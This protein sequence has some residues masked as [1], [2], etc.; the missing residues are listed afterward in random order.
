MSGAGK[1][2]NVEWPDRFTLYRVFNTDTE[3][4]YVGET[5]AWLEHR[6]L[7]RRD[8]HVD[9]AS[10][11]PQDE[12]KDL[13]RLRP[14]QTALQSSV[15]ERSHRDLVVSF[16]LEHYRSKREVKAAESAANKGIYNQVGTAWHP[17]VNL[18]FPAG[19]R[20]R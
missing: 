10:R 2:P 18:R 14:V 7:T 6:W 15:G 3:L 17:T 19:P 8:S 12:W 20:S 13:W 5:G 11:E 4:L 9:R 16:R 1:R